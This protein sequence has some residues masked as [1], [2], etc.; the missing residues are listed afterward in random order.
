MNKGES[1][2]AKAVRNKIIKFI[3]QKGGAYY[4]EIRRGVGIPTNSQTAYHLGKL[5]DFGTLHKKGDKYFVTHNVGSYKYLEIKSAKG[6][7]IERISIIGLV[8]I[9]IEN[10]IAKIVPK[11]PPS[12]CIETVTYPIRN[13]AKYFIENL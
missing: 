9:Q 6:K 4:S 5:I 10:K 12:Y 3:N 7:V 8:P 2:K 13:E 1:K 11:L